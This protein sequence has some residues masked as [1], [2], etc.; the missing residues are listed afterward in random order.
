MDIRYIHYIRT[1]AKLGSISLAAN[2]LFI[3]QPSL[4]QRLRQYEDDLGYPIFFRTQK[5][6]VLTREGEIF[7][8]TAR[9]IETW[10]APCASSW[11]M[12]QSILLGR[13]VLAFRLP[14]PQCFFLSSSHSFSNIIPVL[15]CRSKKVG[16]SNWNLC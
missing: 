14:G 16:R 4:S 5:G 13:Y 7:L 3:S 15:K 6:L 2:E 1:I 8:K 10:N 9:Q 11:Q 12:I